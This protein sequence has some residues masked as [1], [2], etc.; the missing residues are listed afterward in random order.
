[1]DDLVILAGKQIY[2]DSRV[3]AEKFRQKHSHVTKLIRKLILDFN[4]IKGNLES[5]LIKEKEEEYRGQKYTYYEMDKVFFTHLV[6]RFRGT[7]SLEWQ[8]KFIQAFFEME[9]ALVRQSNLEWQRE[10]EQGKQI[11]LNLVDEIKTFIDYATANGSENA[12]YYY[13]TI[14][15]MQYKALGL[16]ENNEK[17]NKDFRNTLDVMDL[18]NLLS[19]EI[20]ARKALMDGIEQKLHYKDIFQLAKNRVLQFA[21][22]V[23]IAP[24]KLIKKLE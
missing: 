21:D 17:I 14:T 2:C 22:I 9:K 1:M 4:E 20:I 16:I 23:L 13:T 7:I 12:Q 3:V 8:K 6:M 15:K 24:D 18:H 19:S 11:R 5:P 10:R